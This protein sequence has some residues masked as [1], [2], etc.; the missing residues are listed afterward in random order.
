MLSHCS[1]E[2]CHSSAGAIE[3]RS[4][5]CLSSNHTSHGVVVEQQGIRVHGRA[6]VAVRSANSVFTRYGAKAGLKAARP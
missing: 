6:G 5:R 3:K 2:T 1:V 4:R